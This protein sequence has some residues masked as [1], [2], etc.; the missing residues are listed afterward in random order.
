MFQT[1]Q[2][3]GN[4]I[5]S[6]VLEPPKTDDILNN[7]NTLLSKCGINDCPIDIATG[8]LG[9]TIQRPTDATVYTLCFIYLTLALI[10][11]CLIAFYLDSFD[12]GI[13]VSIYIYTSI[14]EGFTNLLVKLLF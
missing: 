2:I 8:Q 13:L 1:S 11:I 9:Q 10:S 3:L 5:S 12:S 7:T 14:N 4:L 6:L